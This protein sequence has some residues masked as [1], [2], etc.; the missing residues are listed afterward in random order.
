MIGCLWGK[1]STYK[2]R[3]DS[4]IRRV[5]RL[6]MNAYLGFLQRISGVDTPCKRKILNGLISPLSMP[7]WKLLY[8][9][10]Q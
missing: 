9:Y 5:C 2:E 10:L 4:R 1:I 6:R 7:S 3:T 8:P